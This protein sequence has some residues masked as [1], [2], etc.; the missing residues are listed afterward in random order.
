MGIRIEG[1]LEGYNRSAAFSED[2]LKIEIRGPE[3]CLCL[4][5]I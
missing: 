3:V 5:T 2:I 1:E 4:G